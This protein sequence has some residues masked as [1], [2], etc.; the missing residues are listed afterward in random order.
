MV[1]E[2]NQ[3]AKFTSGK[4]HIPFKLRFMKAMHS[5]NTVTVESFTQEVLLSRRIQSDDDDA[6]GTESIMS[7]DK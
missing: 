3:K 4:M 6:S 2:F 5:L 1:G 7:L